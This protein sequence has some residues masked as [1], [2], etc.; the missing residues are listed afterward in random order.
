MTRGRSLLFFLFSFLLTQ[1]DKFYRSYGCS[2]AYSKLRHASRS[3]EYLLEPHFFLSLSFV[4]SPLI[5]RERRKRRQRE[6]G[7]GYV[8]RKERNL[9][10]VY[11]SKRLRYTYCRRCP[12]LTVGWSTQQRE[13]E[14]QRKESG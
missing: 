5:I 9:A 4:L 11:I 14:R 7:N 3:F 6:K 13:R 1:N 12:Y 10:L 8:L 2:V